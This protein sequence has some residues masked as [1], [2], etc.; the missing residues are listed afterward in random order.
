M[1]IS[2]EF[3][4]SFNKAVIN[5]ENIRDGLIDWNYVDSDVFMDMREVK[6]TTWHY[7]QLDYLI[8]QYEQQSEVTV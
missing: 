8:T 3:V 4:N 2:T 1:V 7:D 6:D 5:P